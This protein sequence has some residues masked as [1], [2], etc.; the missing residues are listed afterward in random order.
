[1]IK[2]L[3]SVLIAF[4]M[5]VSS[6]TVFVDK[7][8][9]AVVEKNGNFITM[10]SEPN[11]FDST[12]GSICG[13]K[14]Y[15]NK[16]ITGRDSDSGVKVEPDS[17]Y[18]F[19][20]EFTSSR[21]TDN[22]CASLITCVEDIEIFKND[23]R[24]NLLEKDDS[25]AELKFL[26]SLTA[27]D[28]NKY[29]VL[30]YASVYYGTY[31]DFSVLKSIEENGNITANIIS[32][33]A[34]E[35]Y[36]Y[37]QNGIDIKVFGKMVPIVR[38]YIIPKNNIVNKDLSIVINSEHLEDYNQSD[39]FCEV[40]W[41]DIYECLYVKGDANLSGKI[42]SA[43]ASFVLKVSAGLKQIDAENVKYAD[44]NRDGKVNARDALLILQLSA[45]IIKNI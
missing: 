40:P 39:L 28:F 10:I 21:Y 37:S 22:K 43:D 32:M 26:Y 3:C 18:I 25:D 20:T 1:M 14:M 30:A 23:I 16:D 17:A 11:V 29:D 36:H 34:M 41:D 7:A 35:K 44:V 5:I 8:D 13:Y 27:D 31:G 24:N 6:L 4:S 9:A 45:G 42:N 33:N 38:Y 2:K 19:T 12:E 15:Y